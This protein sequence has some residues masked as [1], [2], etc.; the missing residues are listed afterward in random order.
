[1]GIWLFPLMDTG[2]SE[3]RFFTHSLQAQAFVDKNGVL[4][5]K[6]HGGKRAFNL[7]VVREMKG[8]LNH[9]GKIKVLPFIRG[10]KQVQKRS[11]MAFFN[12]SRTPDR[13]DSVKWV[14][15]FQVEKDYFYE[16]KKDPTGI[17]TLEDARHVDGI[18]VLG[19]G[20]HHRILE[21]KGFENIESHTS[22]VGCFR[23][24]KAGRVALTVSAESTVAKKLQQTGISP[25]EIWQTPVI[26]L[27]SGGYIAFSKNISDRVIRQWQAA[28][29]RLKTSGRFEQLY[30]HYFLPRPYHK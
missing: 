13:E 21:E 17:R 5:G 2:V 14:G 30:R 24:L 25:D 12:V 29:D 7:E 9:T 27:E 26:L 11:D 19:N 6:A 23:M 8:L 10:L 22:Y 15:P 3:I 4:R 18:C 1:M 28:F 16:M 20:V